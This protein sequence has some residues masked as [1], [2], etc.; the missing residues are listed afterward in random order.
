MGFGLKI[1]K[2]SMG[3]EAEIHSVDSTNLATGF[4]EVV[5][6]CV[7]KKILDITVNVNGVEPSFSQIKESV[8]KLSQF[9][10]SKG[11]KLKIIGKD[12]SP[13]DLLDLQ[14]SGLAVLRG[15]QTVSASFRAHIKDWETTGKL[16]TDALFLTDAEL[17]KNDFNVLRD[18]YEKLESELKSFRA[19][20]DAISKNKISVASAKKELG[21]I[22]GQT[23]KN[24]LN[25]EEISKKK[26]E[27]TKLKSAVDEE[28]KKTADFIKKSDIENKKK[29]DQRKKEEKV[30][31]ARFSKIETEFT[32]QSELR[33]RELEKLKSP[34]PAKAASSGASE[35][36]AKK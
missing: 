29:E 13:Q 36:K 30:E 14:K 19:H 21:K 3:D 12:L 34:A 1:Q 10:S 16:P 25:L 23:D 15:P 26:T 4:I 32:R 31:Q 17:Q 33:A 20:K 7:A 18:R 11:H 22:Q 35:T 8:V 28:E 2:G 5:K 24:K 6:Q 27:L 9:V